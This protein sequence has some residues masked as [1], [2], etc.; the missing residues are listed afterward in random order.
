MEAS[1]PRFRIFTAARP[2]KRPSARCASQTVPHPTLTNG[3]VE[4]V[5]AQLDAGETGLQRV[6]E[7]MAPVSDSLSIEQ[8]AKVGR[9]IRQADG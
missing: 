3:V 2:S 5:G 4:P 9:E 1:S 8:G 6:K 7:E